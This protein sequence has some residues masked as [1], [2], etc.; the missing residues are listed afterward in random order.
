MQIG[1]FFVWRRN[2]DRWSRYLLLFTRLFEDVNLPFVCVDLHSEIVEQAFGRVNL[3]SESA[4]RV[5]SLSVSV[6]FKYFI[7][8]P[9]DLSTLNPL[10]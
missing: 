5:F 10:P 1:N 8:F 3:G 4:E 2:P 6:I 7:T 9:L